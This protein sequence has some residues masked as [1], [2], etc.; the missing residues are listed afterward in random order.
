MA[1]VLFVCTGNICRSPSA[2]GVF[3][4]LVQ[5]AGL[6]DQFHIDSAGTEGYHRGEPPDERSQHHA[7]LRGY[8]LSCQRA[9]KVERGDFTRFEMILAMDRSH[10]RSLQ[11]MAPPR[12]TASLRLFLDYAPDQPMRDV[13]DPYYGGAQGFE[14]V[15][16]LIEAGAR[17]LLA[18]LTP[19]P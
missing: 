8:D 13:P 6:H 4:A 15:L 3:R 19:R 1:S 7:A 16:D 14:Q 18:A 11:H 12:S 2:E 5:Q 17:G 9:R 10:L